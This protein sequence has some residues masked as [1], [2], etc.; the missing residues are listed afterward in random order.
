M[1]EATTLTDA[2]RYWTKRVAKLLTGKM[3]GHSLNDAVAVA[4]RLYH[5]EEERANG[6]KGAT[7]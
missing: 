4:I 6:G 1:S 2:D 3:R 5:M 7:R